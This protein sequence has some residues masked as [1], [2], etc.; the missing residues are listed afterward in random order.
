VIDVKR[1]LWFKFYAN[2]W[3]QDEDVALMSLAAQGLYVRLLALQWRDVTLNS[4]PVKLAK[5]AGIEAEAFEGLWPEISSKFTTV[6]EMPGRIANERLE[7]ERL[8]DEA[9]FADQK[10]R[11]S[12]GGRP[13]G[14]GSPTNNPEVNPEVNPQGNPDKTHIR[15]K[16]RKKEEYKEDI[17]Y[18]PNGAAT[19][20]SN[21]TRLFELLPASHQLKEIRESV[22]MYFSMRKA[23]RYGSWA[24]QTVVAH[25]R[26]FAEFDP[27]IVDAALR[28]AALHEWRAVMPERVQGLPRTVKSK[29]SSRETSERLQREIEERYADQEHHGA[30]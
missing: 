18:A 19:K 9:F 14:G 22:G 28:E 8:G 6:E 25:A 1:H 24:E 13:K 26:K 5:L 2:V 16:E 30:A 3:L 12:L 20:K 4:D 15:S 11:G 23:K 10:R 17:K 27:Q 21:A 29:E 7:Q